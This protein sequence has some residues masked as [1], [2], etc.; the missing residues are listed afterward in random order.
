MAF[1]KFG[2]GE[3]TEVEGPLSKTAA[4]VNFDDQDREALRRENEQA[5]SAD[6]EK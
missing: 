6:E 4:D 5:D 2:T 3:V 1:K